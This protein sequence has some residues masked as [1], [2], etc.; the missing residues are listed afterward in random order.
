MKQWI[1]NGFQ[2]ENNLKC[3]FLTPINKRG[4]PKG[5]PKKNLSNQAHPKKNEESQIQKAQSS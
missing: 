2:R 1:A 3:E 5:V 4:P